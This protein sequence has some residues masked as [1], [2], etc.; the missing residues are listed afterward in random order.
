[1][2]SKSKSIAELL[3]GDVTVTAT[4]IA[5]GSVITAKIADGNIS[6]GKIADN[7]VTADKI[8]DNVA[9]S[10]TTTSINGLTPQASNM[11]G[12]NLVINGAMAVAQRGTSNSSGTTTFLVDRWETYP[13]A[14]PS[15]ITTSQQS[16]TYSD[17]MTV[18]EGFTKYLQVE[19]TTGTG[20]DLYDNKTFR[21]KVENVYQLAGRTATFSFW[22]KSDSNTKFGLV[23]NV[24]AGGTNTGQVHK[25]V[26]TDGFDVTSTWQRFSVTVNIESITGTPTLSES[27]SYFNFFI[28]T[29]N[30]TAGLIHSITGVQ[31]EVGSTASSFAHE[32]YADTLQKCQRYYYK[33]RG[34]TAGNPSD[35]AVGTLACWD[36]V[37]AYG[38]IYYPHYMRAAPSMSY[39]AALNDFQIFRAGTAYYPTNIVT[40]GV[41]VDRLE[42][43]FQSTGN[44]VAGQASWVR[45]ADSANGYLAF[46]AEL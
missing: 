15:V 38:T 46:D 32:S 34:I 31:L 19:Y 44:S 18:S 37:S 41:C 23:T 9:L 10:G 40:T 27:T 3:N 13:G 29:D 24:V 8:V 17:S 43:I 2:A 36:S 6:T 22:A 21:Y 4:D 7:A 42:V 45:I 5:D 26:L 35:A 39:G 33:L 11:S 16:F 30:R 14:N 20:I 28:T 25:S 1:M 12:T